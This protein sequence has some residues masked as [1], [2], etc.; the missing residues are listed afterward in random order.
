M[1]VRTRSIE[2]PDQRRVDMPD[3]IRRRSSNA[4]LRLGGVDASTRP[5]PPVPPHQPVP[6][7]WGSENLVEPLSKHR[8]RS[9]GHVTVFFGS[10]HLLDRLDLASRQLLRRRSW[11]RGHI[12]ETALILSLPRMVPRMRQSKD[13][14]RRTQWKDGT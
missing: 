11:T 2:Q 4:H 13:A 12:V 6:G 3:L 1:Q 10:H 9:R 14:Q 7:G 8:Q 5:T